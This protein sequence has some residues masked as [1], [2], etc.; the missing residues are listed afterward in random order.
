MKMKKFTDDLLK[1]NSYIE[2]NIKI[3]RRVEI[4]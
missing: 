3:T 1:L 4:Y 2:R